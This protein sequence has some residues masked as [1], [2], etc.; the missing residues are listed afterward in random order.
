MGANDDEND[1]D[2]GGQD[3]H[4]G[5]RRSRRLDGGGMGEAG[6]CQTGAITAELIVKERIV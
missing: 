4:S 6:A 3:S 5:G 2:D 1:D